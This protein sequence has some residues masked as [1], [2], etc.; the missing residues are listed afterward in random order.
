M[1]VKVISSFVISMCFGGMFQLRM[2]GMLLSGLAG[3]ISWLV[4]DLSKHVMTSEYF[5]YFLAS[6]ALNVYAE[7]MARKAKMPAI[8]FIVPGLVPLV[9][10]A[11][12]YSTMYNF[13]LN[14]P[15]AAWHNAIYAFSTVVSI[16]LGFI[17]SLGIA[18]MRRPIRI[19][20][21]LK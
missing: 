7:L 6:C 3:A 19:P 11:A 14:N 9:P 5:S 13:V 10:G 2:K 12:L 8:C 18:R 16:A 21:K 17:L 15:Q 1:I 20:F 4:F